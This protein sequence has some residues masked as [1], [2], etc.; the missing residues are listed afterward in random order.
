MMA[1]NRDGSRDIPMGTSIE[2]KSVINLLGLRHQVDLIDHL[3]YHYGNDL[4]GV[5]IRIKLLS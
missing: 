3:L 2:R 4:R 1:G 5:P